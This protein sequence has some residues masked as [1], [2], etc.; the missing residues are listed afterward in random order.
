MASDDQEDEEV[1]IIGTTIGVSQHNRL[2]DYHMQLMLLEQQNRKRLLMKRQKEESQRTPNDQ[3]A[4]VRESRGRD[5]T[6][7]V[8]EKQIQAAGAQKFSADVQT[9][10]TPPEMPTTDGDAGTASATK[11]QKFSHPLG[12][13]RSNVRD[14]DRGN[15]GNSG[16]AQ[17]GSVEVSDPRLTQTGRI[18][19]T[20][21]RLGRNSRVAVR[22]F[23]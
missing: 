5:K 14:S 19:K 12:T 21:L 9:S 3:V 13:Q 16:V 22:A 20:L 4:T 11:R 10:Q 17:A 8:K 1:N 23:V 7:A 6:S 15:G 2:Q 18:A